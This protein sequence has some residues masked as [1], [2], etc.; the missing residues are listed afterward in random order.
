MAIVCGRT[1]ERAW[2]YPQ[3][4]GLGVSSAHLGLGLEAETV[5][6]R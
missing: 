4:A 6:L 1:G 3:V 5:G 2:K